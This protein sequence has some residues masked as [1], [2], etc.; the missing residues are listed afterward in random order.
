MDEDTFETVRVT[1]DITVRRRHRHSVMTWDFHDLID[2]DG[3]NDTMT[4][5][6]REVIPLNEEHV[7]LLNSE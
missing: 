5:V 1:M 6:T 2:C 4:V 7:K 3:A